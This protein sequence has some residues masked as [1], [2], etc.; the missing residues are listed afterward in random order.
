MMQKIKN[1]GVKLHG[2]FHIFSQSKATLWL[3]LGFLLAVGV[4]LYL[5]ISKIGWAEVITALPGNPAFYLVFV[6]IYLALPLFEVV[7]YQRLWKRPLWHYAPFFLRKQVYNAALIGYSGEAVF[8]FWAQSKLG[9]T[10]RSALMAIKDNNILS[11]MASNSA[12]ILLVLA[13]IGTGQISWLNTSGNSFGLYI[14]FGLGFTLMSSMAVYCFRKKLIAMPGRDAV[15]VLAIHVFRVF[16]VMLL[17]ALQWSIVIPQAPFSVWL[18]FLTAQFLMTRIPFLPNKDLLFLG[19][20]L[21]LA[22]MVDAPSAVVAGMFLASGALTQAS[23]LVVFLVTS[24]TET[25]SSEVKP[26]ES[27][28]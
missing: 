3:R 18:A 20:S 6:L 25:V 21:S 9:L 17:Q 14:G 19:L 12:T 15:I 1:T 4:Y 7:I 27:I 23:N 2:L 16:A 28:A 24:L 11:A 26:G 5:K 13:F 8:C 22:G 10:T